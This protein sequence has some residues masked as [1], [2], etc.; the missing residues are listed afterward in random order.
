MHMDTSTIQTATATA[1]THIIASLLE[2]RLSNN[3]RVTL[4]D[5][6]YA[7][8]MSVVEARKTLIQVFGSRVQFKRGRTGGIL[9]TN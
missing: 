7:G 4:S 1:S 5:L 6:A 3:E 9:L 2:T 8:N